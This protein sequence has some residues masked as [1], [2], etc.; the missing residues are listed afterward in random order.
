MFD[1]ILIANR[2]E[3]A[4][5]VIRSC[6][7]LEIPS[8]AVYSECDADSLHVRFADEAICIGPPPSAQS[9]LNIGNIISAAEISDADA[10]HPGYGFLAENPQ[11]ARICRQCQ[12]EFIGPP[13][14]VIE[15]MGDKAEAKRTAQSLGVP[16]IP[17]SDGRVA[18]IEE[19]LAV[20]NECG[21]PVLIKAVAGGGGRGMRLVE[22]PAEFE[23]SWRAAATEAELAF[24][25]SALYI[26]KY[27]HD[28]KHIEIQVMGDKHGN[29]VHVG[30]RDCSV[31]RRRQKLIEETPCVLLPD[32]V[33][34]E[35]AECALRLAKAVQYVGAGTIEFLWDRKDRFY[36][37]EMNT[38]LQ[39]E[40]PVTESVT[41]WDLVKEQISIAAGEPLSRRQED[42]S[43]IGH[44]IECRINA[45]DPE[46]NFLPCPGKLT[47]YHQ[48][49]GSGVRVD[50]HAYQEYVMP[51]HYDSLMGKLIVRAHDR[52]E[53]IR[54]MI[55]CL[56][57]YIIEGVKTTI[58][59][60]LKMMQNARF[61]GG[62]FG[63]KF[64]EQ[65]FGL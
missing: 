60:H 59:F 46:R 20:A 31:Q 61:R 62:D 65:D 23:H 47:T 43:F 55:R 57:E 48:P 14:E 36:F 8:V 34:R 45:E 29:A 27:L 56:D 2:G 25:N 1:K 54:R 58:P 5:R 16:V 30:E 28:P 9:Y 39:V 6:R 18:T 50:S 21:L 11:F 37:M 12:I 33:R 22:T 44:S 53:A 7:E 32:S 51:P 26:E 41:L 49:G 38:R 35:M 52:D 17:G 15:K 10:I 13:A 64:L 63:I 24:G 40:H 4:L 19:G 42:I 3:I